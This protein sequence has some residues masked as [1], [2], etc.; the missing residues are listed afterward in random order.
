MNVDDFITYL[1]GVVDNIEKA[2][3]KGLSQCGEHLRGNIVKGIRDQKHGFEP[4]KEE[5]LKAKADTKRKRGGETIGK[6]SSLI[7]IDKS[8]YVSSFSSN[9]DRAKK[10]VIVGTDHDQ[11]RALEFGYEP[12]NLPARP[13]IGPALDE[14]IPGFET[15]LTDVLQEAFEE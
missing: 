9:V 8:D 11:G 3:V 2:E 14:S 15:I 10:S 7:L 13:H 4:L 12:R 5:T 1:D 6:G